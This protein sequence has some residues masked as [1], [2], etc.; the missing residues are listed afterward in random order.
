MAGLHRPVLSDTL[1]GWLYKEGL[2]SYK[3]G[4]FPG[5]WHGIVLPALL[6]FLQKHLSKAVE[7]TLGRTGLPPGAKVRGDCAQLSIHAL[8]G[9]FACLREEANLVVSVGLHK[10]RFRPTERTGSCG[11]RCPEG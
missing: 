10:D 9:A 2:V 1:A 5:D 3:H 6:A 11:C 8:S 7:A 4:H